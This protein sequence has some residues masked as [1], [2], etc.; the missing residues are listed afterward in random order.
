MLNLT[1]VQKLNLIMNTCLLFE[2]YITRD[3]KIL[4]Y[5]LVKVHQKIIQIQQ[6]SHSNWGL[7][8]HF[9]FDHVDSSEIFSNSVLYLAENWMRDTVLFV[10]RNRK[11]EMLVVE[12]LHKLLCELNFIGQQIFNISPWTRNCPNLYTHETHQP[13]LT[14]IQVVLKF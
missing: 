11:L 7:S 13:N 14:Y 10:L 5:N 2:M 3:P 8:C 9:P 12:T 1:L 6:R 4:T